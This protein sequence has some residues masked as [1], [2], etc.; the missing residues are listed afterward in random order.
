MRILVIEDDLTLNRQL[1]GWISESRYDTVSAK[2]ELEAET[3]LRYQ[4]G[5]IDIALVDM[6]LPAKA[7]G[8]DFRESGLRLIQLMSRR[9]PSIVS[10]VYTGHADLENAARCMEAG[11]FSYCAK[12]GKPDELLEKIR[13]AGI[14]RLKDQELMKF[15][16]EIRWEVE[17]VHR[18]LTDIISVIGR[19]SEVVQDTSNEESQPTTEAGDD[20]GTREY[21]S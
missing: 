11:A 4:G 14:K 19:I 16:R 18:R 6:F 3:V 12:G 2:T 10:V 7:N 13:K 17:E 15:V 8:L 5:S 20:H 9:Y 1:C 21:P